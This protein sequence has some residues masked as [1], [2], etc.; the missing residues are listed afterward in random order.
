MGLTDETKDIEANSVR[1]FLAISDFHGHISNSFGQ[2]PLI[3]G[4]SL[5]KQPYFAD[6][7]LV[8]TRFVVGSLLLTIATALAYFGF[9]SF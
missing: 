6:Y 4:A 9:S 1:D 7:L 3:P 5:E 8:L 2:E